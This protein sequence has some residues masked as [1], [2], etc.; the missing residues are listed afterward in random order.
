MEAELG[1]TGKFTAPLRTLSR[2]ELAAVILKGDTWD[3]S[4][5][6]IEEGQERWLEAAIKAS[7]AAKAKKKARARGKGKGK[8]L[9]LRYN[10]EVIEGEHEAVVRDPRKESKV[11]RL[12]TQR[13]VRTEVYQCR[14]EVC[15]SVF[16]SLSS[17]YLW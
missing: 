10:G 5:E 15:L 14:Y 16:R 1:E 11:K 2:R 17:A 13:P 7:D 6:T 8:E 12:Q 4:V 3:S 9:I